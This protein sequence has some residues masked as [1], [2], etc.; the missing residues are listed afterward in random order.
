MYASHATTAS[1]CADHT[2]SVPF[3]GPVTIN[4]LSS[5][6]F[7]II[8]YSTA[9]TATKSIDGN[10]ATAA[11]NYMERVPGATDNAHGNYLINIDTL[12]SNSAAATVSKACYATRNLNA[13]HIKCL[14]HSINITRGAGPTTTVT[15]TNRTVCAARNKNKPHGRSKT[16]PPPAWTQHPASPVTGPVHNNVGHR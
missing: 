10:T 5:C 14:V 3:Y 2:C 1:V 11:L 9:T 13:T 16:W 12:N 15:A 8:I 4:T 7:L 6:T